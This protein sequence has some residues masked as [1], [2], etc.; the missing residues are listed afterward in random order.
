MEA[1]PPPIAVQPER[2]E[3][4]AAR[5]I[6]T[7]NV[8]HHT[9]DDTGR[10]FRVEYLHGSSGKLARVRGR[11]AITTHDLPPAMRR[12]PK[13]RPDGE[14]A[15]VY[16]RS[17][18]LKELKA[19]DSKTA[20]YQPMFKKRWTVVAEDGTKTSGV[21]WYARL[22]SYWDPGV[23]AVAAE[24]AIRRYDDKKEREEIETVEQD[25]L[26]AAREFTRR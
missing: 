13:L 14:Y 20:W 5:A 7:E 24:L 19:D 2:S 8:Y 17:L 22:G 23:A 3:R 26:D 21:T 18:D 15:H 9:D 25:I 12:L 10:K 11:V 16:K 6:P 4:R 1:P